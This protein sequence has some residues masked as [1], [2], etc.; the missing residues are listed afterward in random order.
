MVAMNSQT[1]R[2]KSNVWIPL[3]LGLLLSVFYFYHG[4]MS[5]FERFFSNNTITAPLLSVYYQWLSAVLIFFI[6]PSLTWTGVMGYRLKEMGL[7]FGDWKKGLLSL[8]IGIP[9]MVL[10]AFGASQMYEFQD[11]Y[12]LYKYIGMENLWVILRYYLT[13]FLFYFSYEAFIRGFIFHAM[14]D[15]IG[16]LGAILIAALVGAPVYIGAS[17]M[18]GIMSI[19]LHM[20]FG[21][22]A[23]KTRSFLYTAVL[24]WIWLMAVDWF[25]ILGV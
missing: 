2:T 17:E 18:E 22:V 7:R 12:P 25:I 21:V 13:A 9:L 8:A 15:E 16:V 24:G 4:R 23:W 5:T 11:I 3:L 10:Y 20:A 6:I 1:P 14:K 19:L